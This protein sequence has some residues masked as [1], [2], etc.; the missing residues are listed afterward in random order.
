MPRLLELHR[1][2]HLSR[3]AWA[4][5]NAIHHFIMTHATSEDEVRPLRLRPQAGRPVTTD[6]GA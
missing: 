5:L 4:G 2:D 6:R 3:T 1:R